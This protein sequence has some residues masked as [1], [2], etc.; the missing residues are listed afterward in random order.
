MCTGYADNSGLA[1]LFKG[2]ALK[3][4]MIKQGVPAGS[5]AVPQGLGDITR[6]MGIKTP[7]GAS[8]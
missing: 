2:N 1:G 7:A 8:A 3:N 6:L 5:G 4:G